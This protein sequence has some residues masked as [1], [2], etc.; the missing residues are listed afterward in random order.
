MERNCSE[1]EPFATYWPFHVVILMQIIFGFVSASLAIPTLVQCKKLYFHVNCKVCS[2]NIPC[3]INYSTNL[4]YRFPDSSIVLLNKK[5]ISGMGNMICYRYFFLLD[6]Y[7]KLQYR[8][9][10][11]D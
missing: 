3:N 1:Y 4:L 10:R 6:S 5:G 8:T 2:V 9:C 7:H 11:Y